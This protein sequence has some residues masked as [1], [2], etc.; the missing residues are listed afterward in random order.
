MFLQTLLCILLIF[1]AAYFGFLGYKL[2]LRN[3]QTGKGAGLFLIVLAGLI[4][5]GVTVAG[6]S[7]SRLALL[8]SVRASDRPELVRQRRARHGV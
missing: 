5:I 1:T 7:W 6:S 4:G 8:P 2:L 3:P